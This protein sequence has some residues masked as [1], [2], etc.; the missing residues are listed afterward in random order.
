MSLFSHEQVC[1]AWERFAGEDDSTAQEFLQDLVRAVNNP[2]AETLLTSEDGELPDA[3][4]D[5]LTQLLSL[6]VDVE[7]R[8]AVALAMLRKF[9]KVYTR[10]CIAPHCFK[11]KIAG[12]HDGETWAMA[13]APCSACA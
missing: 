7:R 12:F 8:S 3:T 2:A 5:T 1:R 10:C 6:I 13:S 11:C 9:P 4:R